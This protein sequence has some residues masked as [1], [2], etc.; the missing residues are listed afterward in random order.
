M[1]EN[2]LKKYSQIANIIFLNIFIYHKFILFTYIS[3]YF[4]KYILAVTFKVNVPSGNLLNKDLFLI[5]GW[6]TV[7]WL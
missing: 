6:P 2:Y 5:H 4:F 7:M 1:Q 3:L